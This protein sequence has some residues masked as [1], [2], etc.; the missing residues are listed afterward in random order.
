MARL[1]PI[2]DRRAIAPPTAATL[3]LVV[4]QLACIAYRALHGGIGGSSC[5]SC[6]CAIL[7]PLYQPVTDRAE[8]SHVDSLCTTTTQLPDRNM[9][10]G[11]TVRSVLPH[12]CRQVGVLPLHPSLP[13]RCTLLGPGDQLAT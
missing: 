7:I 8:C 1:D 5:H 4:Q 11:P 12:P 9:C 13:D 10:T 2:S 6:E 3:L